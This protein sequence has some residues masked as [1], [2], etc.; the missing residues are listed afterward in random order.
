VDID[1]MIS[2]IIVNYEKHK[3]VYWLDCVDVTSYKLPSCFVLGV[4]CFQNI[5]HVH[6]FGVC[7]GK[8][9]FFVCGRGALEASFVRV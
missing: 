6:W 3:D 1:L 7:K 9:F 4:G 2:I 5:A 8:V